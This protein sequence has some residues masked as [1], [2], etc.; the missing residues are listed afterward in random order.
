M[1]VIIRIPGITFSGA[2]LPK[3]S[4]DSIITS[5]TKFVYDSVDSYSY[6]K[7]AAPANGSPSADS[8]VNLVEGGA[9]GQI[10]SPGSDITFNKG[11]I[12]SGTP[13]NKIVLNGGAN[14]A[15]PTKALAILW[16]KH[17]AQ[18]ATTGSHMMFSLGG[19]LGIFWTPVVSTNAVANS[20]VG[21]TSASAQRQFP[22]LTPTVGTIYQLAI[23][24]DNAGLSQTLYANG[25]LIGT[26]GGY[27]NLG[28]PTAPPQ[29]MAATGYSTNYLGTYYRALY[30][31]LSSG[32]TPLSIVQADYAANSA[33]FS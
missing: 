7:Q 1:S 14:L 27:Q 23:A 9:A 16:V 13:F 29:L 33:R 21:N 26:F 24:F 19:P 25:S 18:T 6:A 30:D 31:D 15:T 3:L 2:G 12:P 8:W 17:L 10:Y 32:A 28:A 22:G 5:G 4:R 20:F 11:F